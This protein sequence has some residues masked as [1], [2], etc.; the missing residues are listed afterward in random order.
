M[1]EMANE[2][3]I[4]LSKAAARL[5]ISQAKLSSMVKKGEVKSKKDIRDRRKTFVDMNE[6]NR[7]FFPPQ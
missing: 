2:Q 3:W 7:L 4:E 1:I 6:L 5:G